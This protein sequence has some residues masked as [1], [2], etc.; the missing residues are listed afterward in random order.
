MLNEEID[1]GNSTKN[2]AGKDAKIYKFLKKT[3][4]LLMII[5]DLKILELNSAGRNL[6]EVSKSEIE[7]N[8]NIEQ[9]LDP[10]VFPKFKSLIKKVIEN[11]NLDKP[12]EICFIAKSGKNIFIDAYFTKIN[13]EGNPA[14]LIK[15]HDITFHKEYEERLQ[16]SEALFKTIIH[17]INGYIYNTNYLNGSVIST[18][19]SPKCLKITGY[20]PE[21]YSN[22][23][24]LWIKMVHPDD[25][26]SVFEFFMNLKPDSKRNSIEHRIIH[27]NGKVRWIANT[28]NPIFNK[29]NELLRLD[30]FII[31]ITDKKN[32]EKALQEKNVFLQTVIDS[33]PNPVFF[34]N[35]EGIYLGCNKA[36]EE[37]T[38][39]KRESIIG[40]SI[41]QISST[42]YSLKSSQIDESLISGLMKNSYYGKFALRDGTFKDLIINKASY[43]NLYGEISGIVGVIVDVTNLKQIQDDL[44]KAIDKL[45]E[46][47]IIINKSS[48][49]VFLFSYPG[50]MSVEFVSENIAQFGYKPNDFIHKKINFSDIVHPDDIDNLTKKFR[51]IRKKNLEEINIEFRI[52]TANKEVRWV[53]SR[54]W[55]RQDP[56]GMISHIQGVLI[57]ITNRKIA[58]QNLIL[59]EERYRTVAENSYDL[60]C[61]IDNESKFVFI[62]PNFKDV[63]GYEKSELIG[64][65]FVNYVNYND[66]QIVNSE[67][68]KNFGRA[69]L[70]FKHK[71][72]TWLWFECT[73]NRFVTNDGK[74]LG[75]IIMRD[76]GERIKFEKQLIQTEKIMAIGE[77]SAMI[78]HEFRN[79]LT[80]V[81]MILQIHGESENLKD[82]EKRSLITAINS[83]YHMEKIVNQLLNFSHPA[84]LEFQNEDPVEILSEI[85]PFIK[86][87]CSKRSI[88]FI[89]KFESGMPGIFMNAQSI[90]DALI[91]LLINATQAFDEN[92][93][94]LTR[95]VSFFSK[96]VEAEENLRDVSF[97]VD[98]VT[99]KFSKSSKREIT[100]PKGTE[101]ILIEISDN[102]IGIDE[103]FISRIF[104]PFFT[105]KEKGSGLGLSIVKRTINSHNGIISVSSKKGIGTTFKIYLPLFVKR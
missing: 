56:F 64:S 103:N 62:S 6:F 72:G 1:S 20:K 60:I 68:K 4:D 79:A 30:G 95:K 2:L 19:H 47:E 96:C 36:F 9:F 16:K 55:I 49:V 8:D 65:P 90:K 74:V 54:N 48:A 23:P 101:C 33:L 13:Y 21:E 82:S 40:K 37:L 34:K 31:D 97:E 100:I 63:L 43:K 28:F 42:K 85:I 102:G 57:D 12:K 92:H 59:S 52:L 7:G 41:H 67:L 18:Y 35:T 80:S 25:R 104:E 27:K 71:D 10:A 32:S 3:S 44:Q 15:G 84:P 88:N 61:E 105:T 5:S 24:L 81:K 69:N 93:K 51:S 11:S 39:M 78:A 38:G 58:E 91:N 99:K 87:E 89:T 76:I 66:I 73:G 70:R 75:V 45:K 26:K 17:N 14:V 50:E 83:I 86:M 53:D 22:D 94:K 77:M 98:D 46:L 29:N